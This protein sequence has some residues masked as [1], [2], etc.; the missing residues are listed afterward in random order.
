[1]TLE[2]RFW[3]ADD[4]VVL[5]RP[6]RPIPLMIGSNGPRMLAATLPY[7]DRWNTWYDRY[8][9]TIEGF[10]ELNAFVTRAVRASPAATRPGSTARPRCWSSSIPDAAKRP[11]S[12]IRKQSDPITPDA[13]RAHLEG[14]E[15]AGADEAILILRPITEESIRAVAGASGFSLCGGGH[16][17]QR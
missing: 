16:R 5:P 15:Q 10:A 17:K 14:L 1:M 8:G 11:H 2:G 12:D 7:V 9:N 6:E 3:Q 4:L 13:L